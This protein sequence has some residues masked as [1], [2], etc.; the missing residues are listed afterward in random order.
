MER[1][2]TAADRPRDCHQ[3]RDGIVFAGV[4]P[5][6]VVQNIDPVLQITDL[7]LRSPDFPG[8]SVR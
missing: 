4:S 2:I 6:L 3:P 8:N 1:K 7:C 5:D